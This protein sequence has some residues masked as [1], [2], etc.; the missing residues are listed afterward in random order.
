[1][2]ILNVQLGR[3]GF[4][5]VGHD[6]EPGNLGLLCALQHNIVSALTE[7]FSHSEIRRDTGVVN[8]TEPF[9]H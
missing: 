2:R 8:M 6:T 5:L 9:G 3:P 7:P 4:G 1:L